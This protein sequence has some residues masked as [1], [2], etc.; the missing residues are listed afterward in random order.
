MTVSVVIR[1]RDEADR[2]RLV[3]ASLSRQSQPAEV[4]VVD[5]GSV[6]HTPEV[7]SEAGSELNLVSLRHVSSRGRSAASNTGAGAASGAILL[8]LDGDTLAHPDFVRNHVRA[9]ASGRAL[10]ARGEAF[11]L[12]C[13]RHFRDPEAGTPM[14]STAGQAMSLSSRDL[15][16]LRVTRTQVGEDF[17]SIERRAAPGVYAGTGPRLLQ[18][19]ELSALRNH[20]DCSVLWAAASGSNQSVPR[21]GFLAAGGFNEAVDINEH[22]ELA[23]RLQRSGHRMV[24]A[25]G[26]R[27]YH[28]IH[29]AGWRDP[30]QDVAWEDAFH[31]AHPLPEVELLPV[32]WA[33]L[34][35]DCPLPEEDRIRSL[36]DLETAAISK[37]AVQ[38]AN[39]RRILGLPARGSQ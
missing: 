33:S 38:R 6:D 22:R 35:P 1:T 2:L 37:T 23:L 9:H 20:E 39:L 15:D 10:I 34:S 28:M 8:F 14:K 3:L 13:T 12:R 25:E 26:A 4:V 17:A 36:P 32:F 30:L 18:D 31:A 29:R 16:R 24:V 5:D 19:I 7:I 21:Q 11:H 27:T